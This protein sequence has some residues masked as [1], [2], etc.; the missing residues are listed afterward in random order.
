MATVRNGKYAEG[1]VRDFL[2]V[3]AEAHV[4]FAYNRILDAH[5]AMG[6]MSNPQPGDFQWFL[7]T[8]ALVEIAELTPGSQRILEHEVPYTRNG[9]I[10][11]KEVKH[12]YRLPYG[13]FGVDQV[14]RMRIRQLAGSEPLV[15]VCFR[16]EGKPTVWRAPG[17]ERFEDRTNGGSWD[18]RDVESTKDVGDIL[19]SY[20]E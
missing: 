16:Q 12:E 8:E 17:F 1:K 10:E 15:L 5:S 3:W 9:L 18:F 2:K 4:G 19:R 20:L 13:N 11:V 14:G 6:A 7:R